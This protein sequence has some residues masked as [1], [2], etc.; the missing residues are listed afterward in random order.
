MAR[1]KSLE[2]VRSRIRGELQ[3]PGISLSSLSSSYGVSI[4]TLSRW[5]KAEG[6][7]AG[8]NKERSGEFIELSVADDVDCE[9]KQIALTSV[10]MTFRDFSLKIEGSITSGTLLLLL[11]TLEKSSC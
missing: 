8:V 1:S 5:R 11:K 6:V 4:G 7:Y 2:E 9:V 3:K 10:A